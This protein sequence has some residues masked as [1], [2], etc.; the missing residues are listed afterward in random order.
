MSID[1]VTYALLKKQLAAAA[2]GIA[3]AIV[4][5]GHL[6]LIGVD[7]TRY[8]CGDLNIPTIEDDVVARDSVW[9]S[10]RIVEYH[11]DNSLDEA[12]V[13]VIV[14]KV[15]QALMNEA[16][17][18]FIFGDEA[19]SLIDGGVADFHDPDLLYGTDA[20]GEAKGIEFIGGE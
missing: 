19:L 14:N 7:G 13:E 8:D 20:D 4:E 15:T 18:D 5:N 12:E 9:S 6:I 11:E 16:V 17:P 2:G 1:L 10:E 3:E